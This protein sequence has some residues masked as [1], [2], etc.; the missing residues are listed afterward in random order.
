MD[1]ANTAVRGLKS[2]SNDRLSPLPEQHHHLDRRVS[3]AALLIPSVSG[4]R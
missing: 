4:F 1:C 3:V 2:L